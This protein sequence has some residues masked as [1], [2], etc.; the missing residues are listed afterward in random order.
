[1]IARLFFIVTITASV[2]AL[3]ATFE[4]RRVTRL[5]DHYLLEL[6]LIASRRAR[7]SEAP[8]Q[9]IPRRRCPSAAGMETTERRLNGPETVE[10]CVSGWQPRLVP[11][12]TDRMSSKESSP[13][14]FGEAGN[15][16]WGTRR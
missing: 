9:T 13:A 2:W 16:F 6:D 7:Q 11:I 12:D 14:L 4:L 8:I 3:G 1:M 10:V 15:V 5:R